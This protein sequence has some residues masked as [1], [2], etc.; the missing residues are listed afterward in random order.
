M[1]LLVKKEFSILISVSPFIAEACNC[2]YLKATWVLI[3]KK[4]RKVLMIIKKLDIEVLL[5]GLWLR[6]GFPP[7]KMYKCD[8]QP[9]RG[10]SVETISPYCKV[11]TQRKY[12]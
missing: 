12:T 9:F 3:S 11:Y 10:G 7:K 2:Q 1:R 6:E 5:L 8:L 4:L